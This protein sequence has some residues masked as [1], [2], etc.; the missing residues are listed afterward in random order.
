M[1]LTGPVRVMTV[2][3]G[4]ETINPGGTEIKNDG[5]D[6]NCN[7]K[8]NCATFPVTPEGPLDLLPFFALF[9]VPAVYGYVLKRRLARNRIK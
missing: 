2:T 1:P 6:S 4:D 5:I 8:D 7:G 9:F 3:T